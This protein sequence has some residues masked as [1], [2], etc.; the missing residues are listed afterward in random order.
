MASA[1]FNSKKGFTLIEV[2]VSIVIALIVFAAV[3]RAV[4]AYMKYSVLNS[5]RNTAVEL[6]QSCVSSLSIG[7]KCPDNA[8]I[9]YRAFEENFKIESPNPSNFKNG[10]NDVSVAVKYK[11]GNKEYFYTITTKVYKGE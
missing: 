1:K 11:Y 2:L 8:T 10:Y 5:L 6:A 3:S 4:V 9:R 7:N